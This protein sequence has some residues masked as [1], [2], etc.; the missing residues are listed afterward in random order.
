MLIDLSKLE[1]TRFELI[2]PPKDEGGEPPKVS[3][4][5]DGIATDIAIFIPEIGKPQDSPITFPAM[6]GNPERTIERPSGLQLVMWSVVTGNPLPKHL[7][8]LKAVYSSLRKIFQIPDHCGENVVRAAFEAWLGE[9]NRRAELKKY[10]CIARFSHYFPGI[11]AA[12]SVTPEMA[13]GMLYNIPTIEAG[14]DIR[15]IMA[16][17]A[18]FGGKESRSYI[19]ALFRT[20]FPQDIADASAQLLDV[21]D[22]RRRSGQ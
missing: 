18:A 21:T 4:D 22:S 9:Q 20:A 2:L 3:L 5:F 1:S 7:P 16:L 11:I 10:A 14:E 6:D 13:E 12:S 17:G 19:D 8:N 15:F